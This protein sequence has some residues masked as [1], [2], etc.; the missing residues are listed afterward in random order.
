MMTKLQVSKLDAARRQLETAIKL[1]FSK[2]DFVSIHSLAFA[3]FQV[4]KNLCDQ[5]PDHP[6]SFSTWLKQSIPDTYQDECHRRMNEAAN[7]FK[8]ADR[9]PAAL[10][11]YIPDQYEFIMMMAIEQYRGLTQE[12]NSIFH[13][14]R[15]WFLWHHQT[16]VTKAKDRQVISDICRRFGEDRGAFFTET[17]SGL[18]KAYMANFKNPGVSDA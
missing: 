6:N 3:A 1:Y 9:D 16:W 12:E 14:F 5:Q 10:L 8:H 13:A 18:L 15:I 17:V 4:T 11:D 7:Y 2:G